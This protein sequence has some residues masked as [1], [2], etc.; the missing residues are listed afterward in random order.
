MS[1]YYMKRQNMLIPHQK[2]IR[3]LWNSRSRRLCS[4]C[5]T[6]LRGIN[7]PKSVYTKRLSDVCSLIFNV[8]GLFY[9]QTTVGQRTNEQFPTRRLRTAG[10]TACV[11]TDTGLLYHSSQWFRG[12]AYVSLNLLWMYVLLLSLSLSR[13]HTHTHAR[14][15]KLSVSD[16]HTHNN[17]NNNKQT[18]KKHQ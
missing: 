18:N 12:I 6:R 1:H 9:E 3:F 14:T 8:C 7:A 10:V 11:S 5:G 4:K 15:H 13:R 2:R 16:T 17:N